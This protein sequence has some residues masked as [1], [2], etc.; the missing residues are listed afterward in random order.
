[1]IASSDSPALYEQVARKIEKLIRSGTLRAGD[2]IPS[3][4][5]ASVQHG[6][7]VTTAVQAYLALE[8][9]GLIEAR[10]K[11][12]FFVRSQFRDRVLEPMASRPAASAQLVAVGSLQ[13]RIFDAA[14]MPDVVPLGAAYPGAENLPVEKLSRVMAAVAREAGARGIAYD[15]PPGSEQLRRQI[16]KR[17][18]DWG[19]NLAPDEIITTCGG[20]EA[21]ALCLRAVTKPGDVVA[22]ESPSY[23]GVL[24]QIEEFGLRA[25]EI[26]MHPR[27]GMDLDA[28]ERA[29]K[30]R[31]L[32][33]C[34]AVP[35][36]NNPLGS[37][38]PDEHKQ[39]L[40]E[41]LAR[42]EVPLIEDDINGALCHSGNRPR[43]VQSYDRA[44]RVLLCGSFSKTLAP[45]YRVGWVA[46]GRFHEKVKALKLTSTLAT[47]SLPQ[48]A[49]A[50]FVANGGYD[51]HLRSLRRNFA[52]QIQRMS[53]AIAEAFPEDIKLTR[54]TG[55]FVLW[56]ELPRNVSALQLHERALAEKISIAP[57][58]MFSASQ[59]FENFLRISCGHPWSSRLERAVEVLGHLVRKLI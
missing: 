17:S 31:R 3:V 25:L 44:G 53:E 59:G 48:L 27:D 35:N 42:R 28:L 12:G 5:R 56:I 46:P 29:V 45:G 51:H 54:P 26:P 10:P 55:G 41:I 37:L 43:V 32:A 19:S 57:G 22:V 24:Q 11:S 16:A 8:N 6:V 40:L 2:R 33:A 13:S 14:R 50:E 20:T 52:A 21:L 23:F 47:A 30:G 1:M 34:L 18:L 58:P 49:I 15:M 9:R 36:F 39:R 4:R 38:M 7:S